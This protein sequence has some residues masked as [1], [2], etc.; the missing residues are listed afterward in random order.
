MSAFV[1]HRGDGPFPPLRLRSV[2]AQTH[3]LAE[4]VVLDA[5]ESS[6]DAVDAE[7][8]A[9]DRDVTLGLGVADGLSR[10]A[11][12]ASGEFVWIVGSEGRSDAAALAAL[13]ASLI[14]EP[15]AAFAFGDSAAADAK[16]RPV[17][18]RPSPLASPRRAFVDAVYEG[19]DFVAAMV[20]TPALGATLWRREALAQALD[21]CGGEPADARAL[22]LAAAAGRRVVYVAETLDF[23]RAG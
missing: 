18:A 13:A 10:A 14:A 17:Y 7:A 19:A 2:F 20:E 15:L 6:L 5:G 1:L 16:V 8:H 12:M 23:V 4:V 21:A 9:A 3:P 11:W 22:Y